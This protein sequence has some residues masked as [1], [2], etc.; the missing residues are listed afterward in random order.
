MPLAPGYIDVMQTDGSNTPAPP[1]EPHRRSS[2]KV[3]LLVILLL[4]AAFLG[5][6]IPQALE[7][8]RVAETLQRTELDLRLANLHRRLGTASH[9]VQ[10]N[11][12]AS[13]TVAARDFFDG[14]AALAQSGALAS[15]PRT[16]IA[17][18]SYAGQRD[19]IMTPLA[20]ADPQVRER[21]AGMYLVMDGVLQRRE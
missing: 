17:I 9:E 19:E 16:Q 10:R 1:P 15:E 4:V 5:G 21:L 12:F 18:A 14:C 11:N 13:A 2:L 8:R 6:Y 20:V 7:L 3:F